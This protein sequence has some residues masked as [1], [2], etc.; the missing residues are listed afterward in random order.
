MNRGLV[1]SSRME[2]AGKPKRDG[3]SCSSCASGREPAG[4][5]SG[6]FYACQAS[7]AYPRGS[8]ELWVL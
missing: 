8:E 7:F 1:V 2:L 3:C 5:R 6:E 4:W